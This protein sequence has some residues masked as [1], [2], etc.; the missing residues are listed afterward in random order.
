MRW[1]YQVV[2]SKEPLGMHNKELHDLGDDG[3]ELVNVV[4]N[5]ASGV[6]LDWIKWLAYFKR[7]VPE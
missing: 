2:E 1:E 3:W 5:H 7:E 6:N 4:L